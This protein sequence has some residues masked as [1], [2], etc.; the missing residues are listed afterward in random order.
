VRD[1]AVVGRGPLDLGERFHE[2]FL[3][4]ARRIAVR[5]PEPSRNSEDVG[6]DRDGLDR[7]DVGEDH[8]GRL[9]PDSGKCHQSLAIVGDLA[10]VLL[11]ESA[12]GRQDVARLVAE[13]PA[14]AD[15]RF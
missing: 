10:V 6:V 1:Q 14:R 8:V 2:L 5:Q 7:M 4:T 15:V 13:E 3:D 12:S 9:T 11:H